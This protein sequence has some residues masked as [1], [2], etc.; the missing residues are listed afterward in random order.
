MRVLQSRTL[1]QAQGAQGVHNCLWHCCRS[2]GMVVCPQLAAARR[3]PGSADP[4]R[5]RRAWPARAYPGPVDPRV[6]SDG[7]IFLGGLRLGQCPRP[8]LDLHRSAS[9]DA[10]Q[11]S[12]AVDPGHQEQDQTGAP[13]PAR[14]S[15][16]CAVEPAGLR[17][18]AAM[19]AMG[20]RPLRSAPLPS[21]CVD[22]HPAFARIVADN[23]QPIARPGH[24][25]AGRGDVGVRHHLS[26]GLYR[27]SLR[28]TLPPL[29]SRDQGH[30]Q[31][32]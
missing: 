31:S 16:A 4:P 20:L 28:Q 23:P 19:A 10:P 9:C 18:L 30:P 32:P 8:P 3:S 15:P 17:G 14:L 21:Y 6:L 25:S 2:S 11:R 29:V 13:H 27:P 7:A 26:P 5:N 24:G 1:R 22:H 12:G